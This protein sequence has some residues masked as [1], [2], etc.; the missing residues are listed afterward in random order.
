[1][2]L[3]SLKNEEVEGFLNQNPLRRKTME[4]STELLKE[5]VQK[6]YGKA[7]EELLHCQV[8]PFSIYNL[9]LSYLKFIDTRTSQERLK[10]HIFNPTIENC[11]AQLPYTI[12]EIVAPETNFLVNSLIGAVVRQKHSIEYIIAGELP[13]VRDD[14][15]KLMDLRLTNYG[16]EDQQ[17]D[18]THR[19]I[20]LQIFIRPIP[21]GDRLK[22]LKEHLEFIGH[23]NFQVVDDHSAL[24]QQTHIMEENLQHICQ[25]VT[26]NPAINRKNVKEFINYLTQGG[27]VFLGYDE[28]QVVQSTDG[29]LNL[30]LLPETCLGI[31]HY[32]HEEIYPNGTLVEQSLSSP[33]WFR[34]LKSTDMSLIHREAKMDI[35]LV[36]K[37]DPVNGQILGEYRLFGLFTAKFYYDSILHTPLASK[38]EEIIQQTL[39][40]S[41][42]YCNRKEIL[43]L[44]ENYP[45]DEL[46]ADDTAELSVNLQHIY[47]LL[48]NKKG[49]RVIVHRDSLLRFLVFV[50]YISKDTISDNLVNNIENIIAEEC[51]A[52]N[53][54]DVNQ[55]I[56]DS[57]LARITVTIDTRHLEISELDIQHLEQKI[58]AVSSTYFLELQEKLKKDC[59]EVEGLRLF[60][61]YKK[62]LSQSYMESFSTGGVSWDLIRSETLL[63]RKEGILFDIYYNKDTENDQKRLLNI[64]I[65]SLNQE[66]VLSK[67]LPILENYDFDIID[68]NTYK[69]KPANSGQEISVY[70]FQSLLNN[71]QRTINSIDKLKQNFA[72]SLMMVWMGKTGNDP[73]NALVLLANLNYHEVE[74]LRTYVAYLKQI[75]L[76]YSYSTICRQIIKYPYL[77]SILVNYFRSKFAIQAREADRHTVLENL[78]TNAQTELDKIQNANDD[79]IFKTFL[80]VLKA[81]VRTNYY[82]H[83]EYLSIKIQSQL[84]PNL[85]LPVPMAEIFVYS[86][87]FEGIHLRLGKVARGGIRWSDRLEDYRTEIL[88]LMKTQN[89]KNSIIVPVGAKGGFVIKDDLIGLEI[90]H[91]QAIGREHY[92]SFM[93]G[94]LDITDNL[95]DRRVVHPPEVVCYDDDDP[96]LVVAADKGTAGFSDLANGIAQS[97]NFWLGDAFASGGSSGYDHKDMGITAKGAWI[98]VKRHFAMDFDHNIQ[99]KDFTVVGIGDMSGDVFGNGMLLSQHIKLVAAFNHR[100]IFLDPTPDPVTSFEERKRLFHKPNSSWED[101]NRQLISTGG[102]VFQRSAKAIVLNDPIRQL[103]DIPVEIDAISPAELIRYILQARVDLLWNGGIGTYIKSSRETNANLGDKHNDP[104][105]VNA[106]TLRCKV[107]GE[108]GNLGFTQAGRVEACQRGIKMNTD[109][110]DNSAGVDCSDHEVNLKIIFAKLVADGKLDLLRRNGLLAQMQNEVASLVLEDNRWQSLAIKIEARRANQFLEVQSNLL[111]ALEDSGLLNRE[112]EGLPN[113]EEINQRLHNNEGLTA[114][115]M[116]VLMAYE[117]IHIYNLLL[118]SNLPDDKYCQN[119]LLQYFPTTIQEEFREEIL[120]HQLAREIIATMLTNL[121]VNRLGISFIYQL[122]EDTG[123]RIEH[124]TKCFLVAWQLFD[125]E[126]SWQEL[127]NVVGQVGTNIHI[128][129]F[130]EIR[131]LATNSIRWMLAHWEE[132]NDLS[133]LMNKYQKQTKDLDQLFHELAKNGLA[134]EYNEKLTFYHQLNI[135]DVLARKISGINILSVVFDIYN[136]SNHDKLSFV[137]AGNIYFTVGRTFGIIDLQLAIKK[138]N[139]TTDYWQ[140]HLLT[141]LAT[142]L[143]ELQAVLA[144]KLVSTGIKL[145]ANNGY[146]LKNL[147]N[148]LLQHQEK[149]E[150]YRLVLEKVRNKRSINDAMLAVAVDKLTTLEQDL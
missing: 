13:I 76:N 130:I 36:Q 133:T 64:K 116:C 119:L 89:A 146:Q 95:Q 77:A 71:G 12:I 125:L 22:E 150:Q 82:L 80:W 34:V 107:V 8:D 2:S 14:S 60:E 50:V 88:S 102:G 83:K 111:N 16:S 26:N 32:N 28:Y 112:V 115:E 68:E 87:H 66:V 53:F 7:E 30:Q 148:L 117:K 141:T 29:R 86:T 6:I 100:H 4:Y 75:G 67:I 96:Y 47:Q 113:A 59:G 27:F 73:L 56:D 39:V 145:D 94:L 42:F 18:T 62:G 74:V 109:A 69:I 123:N 97:Y 91:V 110:L 70:H 51:H 121:L 149:W 55:Y 135:S 104:V 101:Y 52:D 129:L 3:T 132:K 72:D 98:S 108:G 92:S 136:I 23:L 139:N 19:E 105:R 63:A 137:E 45:R 5:F 33:Y 131:Q 49:S 40:E 122:I 114:A 35:L 106:N 61:K 65:Y 1:M 79:E 144:H 138:N 120:H 143:T 10:L 37:V 48:R 85:P 124:I 43:L 20:L 9:A 25:L 147:Q 58:T 15:G 57:G 21:E 118:A 93:R 128:D 46:L 41:G 127:D 24:L 81:T 99:E 84:I 140:K 103:L 44:L 38:A 142:K 11:G 126:N 17:E 78:W 134:P 54:I 31:C 90:P